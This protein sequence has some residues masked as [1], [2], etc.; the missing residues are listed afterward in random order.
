[1]NR[2][3]IKRERECGL[4]WLKKLT[5]TVEGSCK[6]PGPFFVDRNLP[7]R[8]AGAIVDNGGGIGGGNC[9]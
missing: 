1:M 5:W 9:P 4:K 2:V 8:C 7:S 6:F 3:R